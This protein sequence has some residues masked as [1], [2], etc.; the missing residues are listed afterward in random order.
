MSNPTYSMTL[1]QTYNHLQMWGNVLP[2][3][4]VLILSA[5]M[6]VAYYTGAQGVVYFINLLLLLLVS[7]LLMASLL[8]V[9]SFVLSYF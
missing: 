2:Y 6:H 1:S 5:L 8:T 3:R 4:I 7:L 9:S